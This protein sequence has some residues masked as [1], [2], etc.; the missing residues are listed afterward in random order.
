ML[1]EGL[2]VTLHFEWVFVLLCSNQ[3]DDP[4]NREKTLIQIRPTLLKNIIKVNHMTK[5]MI[6][7]NSHTTLGWEKKST[8]GF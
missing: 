5:R 8:V 4:I 1:Y 2:E 3:Q 6:C 7:T